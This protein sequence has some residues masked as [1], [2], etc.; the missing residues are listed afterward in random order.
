MNEPSNSADWKPSICPPL[1]TQSSMC[2]NSRAQ[3]PHFPFFWICPHLIWTL[4]PCGWGASSWKHFHLGWRSCLPC[5][6]YNL[7]T[8]AWS[9]N[10]FGLGL[11]WNYLAPHRVAYLGYLFHGLVGPWSWVFV[12]DGVGKGPSHGHFLSALPKVEALFGRF[13]E[14]GGKGVG[15][16]RRAGR[17]TK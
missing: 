16:R 14:L 17:Q 4:S 12:V 6:N 1:T 7:A 10:P 13:D 2:C 11:G 8:C 15:I 9:R 5:L 3:E